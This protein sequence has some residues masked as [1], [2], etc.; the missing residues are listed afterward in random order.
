MPPGGQ[1]AAKRQSLA[2]NWRQPLRGSAHVREK[3]RAVID[4]NVFVA[5]IFWRGS[6]RE[7]LARFAR[8][9]FY[10]FVTESLLQEYAETAWELKLEEH[11]PQNPQPWLNWITSRAA[12]LAATGLTSQVSTD[13][14]DDKFIECAL[15]ARAHY[16][17]SRDRHLLAL[18]KPF[19][20]TVLDDRAF[21][22]R[23][24]SS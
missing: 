21:L 23:L 1:R 14:D 16:L 3:P 8:R 9:Q 5:A 24:G 2:N 10:L 22:R 7:C 20:I 11:L 15:A 4:T 18:T 19:G 17:V 13:P 12:I 6:A